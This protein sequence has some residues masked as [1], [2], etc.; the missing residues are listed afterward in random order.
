M[1]RHANMWRISDDF[2]D[3]WPAL[4]E[5][6]DR[7]RKWAP[8]CAPG[9]FPDADMLPFGVLDQGRR[10]THFTLDE[11]RTVMTLWSIARSPL[12]MGGDLTKL[13]AATRSLL[14]NDEVIAVDQR[15]RCGHELFNRDGQVAWAADV[16]G[17]GD[18]YVALFNVRDRVATDRPGLPV[19]VRFADLGLA[20]RCSVRD[21]WE[22]RNLGEFAGEFAP[23]IAWHAAGLYQISP[24]Q[25]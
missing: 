14:T 2:W 11:Q 24:A 19:A 13:D 10:T 20:G 21:L 15:S 17:C 12:I 25:E 3:N 8:Y 16:P 5:Q 18:K 4:L 22:K 9:H 6:F 1:V 23:V 7:L